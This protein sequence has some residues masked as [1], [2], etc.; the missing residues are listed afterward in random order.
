M[1]RDSYYF[2]FGGTLIEYSEEPIGSAEPFRNTGLENPMVLLFVGL[3][4][5]IISK[6]FRLV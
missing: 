1:I 4:P 3:M 6:Y 2:N 5:M